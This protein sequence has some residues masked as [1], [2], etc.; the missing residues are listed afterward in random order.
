[1][2]F[3][4]FKHKKIIFATTPKCGIQHVHYLYN[5][6]VGDND[7]DVFHHKYVKKLRKKKYKDYLLIIF[8][9][10]PYKRIVSGFREKY[11]NPW[12]LEN[13]PE[14]YKIPNI[15]YD[16]LTFREFINELY[17]NKF[18]NINYNHFHLQITTDYDF[19]NHKNKLI[20]DIENINYK[21]LSMLFNKKINKKIINKRGSHTNKSTEL[22]LK[23][24]YDLENVIYRKYK[25]P[26]KYYFDNDIKR[27]FDHFYKDDLN[28]MKNNGFDFKLI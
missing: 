2:F 9:R 17:Y 6:L 27:K 5:F 16:K 20:F 28:F 15:E 8:I 11:S 7:K 14:K 10:N 4:I 26:T 19:K 1:M 13:F 3:L 24:V 23:P 12:Q 21:F 25:V 22:Y 18:K